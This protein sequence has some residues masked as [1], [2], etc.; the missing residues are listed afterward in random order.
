MRRSCSSRCVWCFRFPRFVS[1]AARISC[2]HRPH[3]EA[4]PRE[5]TRLLGDGDHATL[6]DYVLTILLET[7][8]SVGAIGAA[9]QDLVG[10]EVASALAGGWL[11]EWVTDLRETHAALE[12][13]EG[14]VMDASGGGG[15]GQSQA[16]HLQQDQQDAGD[17]GMWEEV[18]QPAEGEEEE[19]GHGAA[20][21]RM[22]R[23]RSG[24]GGN[25]S[26][27]TGNGSGRRGGSRLFASALAA[28]VR[29]ARDAPRTKEPPAQQFQLQRRGQRGAPPVL[30][31][32]SMA[33][34]SSRQGRRSHRHGQGD[35][36]PRVVMLEREGGAGMEEEEA[37]EEDAYE[38]N[39]SLVHTGG[40]GHRNRNGHGQQ[41][42]G[43]PRG[44]GS[45]PRSGGTGYGNMGSSP[46][47]ATAPRASAPTVF[48][49][50][51]FGESTGVGV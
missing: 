41:H 6:T 19:K 11:R 47:A 9:L 45:S 26:A 40:N 50:T 10:A 15:Q 33:P 49:I 4:L 46:A 5:L 17:D 25:G 44:G 21:P 28:S 3:Q 7:R 27:A 36:G 48:R 32:T 14:G 42:R 31:V 29:S 51:G 43:Q 8:K 38:R 2:R 35:V 22:A 30:D 13:E 39:V 1:P 37:E 16:L 34:S 24:S 20:A 23:G 18:P 12:G